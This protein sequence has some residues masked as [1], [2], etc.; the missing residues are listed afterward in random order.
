MKK[1]VYCIASLLLA[2]CIGCGTSKPYWSYSFKDPAVSVLSVASSDQVRG[3]SLFYLHEATLSPE[4]IGA[5][6]VEHTAWATLHLSDFYA[7]KLRT[8]FVPALFEA[9]RLP[10]D[11][12]VRDFRWGIVLFDKNGGRL[13][14]IYLAPN[15]A[16]VANGVPIK[17]SDRFMNLVRHLFANVRR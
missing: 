16:G 7:S 13:L 3:F 4:P 17:V 1:R 5:S 2:T 9:K 14:S 8:S 10:E 15:G 6:G 12:A 11:E